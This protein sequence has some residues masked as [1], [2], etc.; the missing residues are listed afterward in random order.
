MEDEQKQTKFNAAL[1]SLERLHKLLDDCNF[2]SRLARSDG[3]NMWGL[4][5][6]SD[7][8]I[9]IR[10]EISP[11]IPD[12]KIL[13]NV[14]NYMRMS[15]ELGSP[16]IRVNTPYGYEN[17]ISKKKFNQQWVL[18]S[19]TETELRRIADKRGLLIPD[20]ETARGSISEME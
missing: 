10:R 13:N 5:V 15:R 6:W 1:S 8:I 18:L 2:Y 9:A 17:Q 4:R 11:K 14:N 20:K 12:K 7:S 16:A 19:K 3:C